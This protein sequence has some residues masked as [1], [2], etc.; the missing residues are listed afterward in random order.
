[1]SGCSLLISM[2]AG[3]VLVGVTGKA[4]L[5]TDSGKSALEGKRTATG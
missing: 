3:Q 5:H 4:A 1:M 2:T